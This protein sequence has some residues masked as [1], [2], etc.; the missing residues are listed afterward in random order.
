VTYAEVTVFLCRIALADVLVYSGRTLDTFHCKGET[1]RVLPHV[2]RSNPGTSLTTV[3]YDHAASDSK[4][5]S[6]PDVHEN[7][8]KRGVTL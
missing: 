4:N 6:W 7:T 8:W 2:G 5:A 3:T 1:T